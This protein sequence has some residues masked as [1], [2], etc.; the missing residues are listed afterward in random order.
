M[1]KLVIKLLAI[2]QKL[3]II[4]FK[5]LTIGIFPLMNYVW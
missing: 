3:L 4:N 5:V 1:K 2:K